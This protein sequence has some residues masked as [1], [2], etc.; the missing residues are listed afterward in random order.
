MATFEDPF[1]ANRGQL[2]ETE[3]EEDDAQKEEEEEEN[4]TI[5]TSLNTMILIAYG[6]TASTILVTGKPPPKDV[7]E[8][9]IEACDLVIDLDSQ[10]KKVLEFVKIKT[11]FIAPNLSAVFVSKVATKLII[12]YKC[13]RFISTC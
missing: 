3:F 13:W 1:L 6:H 2:S 8:K 9:T 10:K 11:R 4:E 5:I 12:T 7:Q